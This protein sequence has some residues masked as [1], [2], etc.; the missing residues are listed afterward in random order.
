M[1][2]CC[3]IENN[4]GSRV[5]TTTR[6][7]DVALEVGDVYNVKPISKDNSKKLLYSS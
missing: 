1:I 3:L 6:I 5:I 2:K 4:C 7:S